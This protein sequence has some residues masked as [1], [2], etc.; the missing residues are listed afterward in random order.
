MDLYLQR[1][2][3]V[4]TYLYMLASGEGMEIG[5]I[6]AKLIELCYMG[7]NNYSILQGLQRRIYGP[8]ACLVKLIEDA[9]AYGFCL[10][11]GSLSEE[12]CGTDR[13]GVTLYRSFCPQCEKCPV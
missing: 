8:V 7:Q 4:N 11:H 5:D 6:Q 2:Q 3:L 9:K 10:W 1:V 13:D 12:P